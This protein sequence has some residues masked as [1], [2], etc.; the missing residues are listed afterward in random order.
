MVK[1]LLISSRYQFCNWY[2][3]RGII[4]PSFLSITSSLPHDLN[5]LQVGKKL[6]IK[7]GQVSMEIARNIQIKLT[8]NSEIFM[9][10]LPIL[11]K[12]WLQGREGGGIFE[13]NNLKLK[14][15]LRINQTISDIVLCGLTCAFKL[16]NWYR[17]ILG[18]LSSKKLNHLKG[19]S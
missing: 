10:K 16:V 13:S 3:K 9:I 15:K 5:C 14:F 1:N 11:K 4:T 12:T 6:E 2:I 17:V 18:Q 8:S 7:L 19:K